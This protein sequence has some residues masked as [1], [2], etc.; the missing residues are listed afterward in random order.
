M[1][2]IKNLVHNVGHKDGET[3]HV[4]HP[5][6]AGPAANENRNGSPVSDHVANMRTSNVIHTGAYGTLGYPGRNPLDTAVEHDGHAANAAR[7]PVPKGVEAERTSNVIHTGAYG[8]TGVTGQNTFDTQVEHGA[9]GVDTAAASPVFP[10]SYNDPNAP[11]TTAG[12]I[13][14]PAPLGP[15]HRLAEQI[16]HFAK[17]PHTTFTANRLD[18]RVGF[19]DAAAIRPWNAGA[20]AGTN[21]VQPTDPIT[22]PA[23]KTAGPHSSDLLNKLDPRVDSDLDGSRTMGSVPGT[24]GNV[25][26]GPMTGRSPYIDVSADRVGPGAGAGTGARTGTGPGTGVAAGRGPVP[27]GVAAKESNTHGH[28]DRH[29]GRDLGVV[30]AGGAVATH[31]AHKHEQKHETRE[32]AK[33]QRHEQKQQQRESKGHGHGHGLFSFLHRDKKET[34]RDE[35]SPQTPPKDNVNNHVHYP[36]Q[37]NGTAHG[38]I[39]GSTPAAA[40][41]VPV[42][43][44]QEKYGHHEKHDRNKLHKASVRY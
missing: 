44:E 2:K 42:A 40:T 9:E 15:Q 37:A 4:S 13:V 22:G 36:N 8:T 1:Q 3:N 26:V 34:R 24:E 5:A 39:L 43:A 31:E 17:G 28:H 32:V 6:N 33:E 18:P 23:P 29:D 16:T 19:D 12:T 27:A 14:A 30:G 25:R 10:N 35:A 7:T 11:T 38:P 21:S 20:E 41:T